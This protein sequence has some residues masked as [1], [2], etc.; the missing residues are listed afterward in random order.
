MLFPSV[1]PAP[2]GQTA[3]DRQEGFRQSLATG[4]RA[5]QGQ[6]MLLHSLS[7]FGEA[8]IRI[9][10][11]TDQ[12]HPMLDEHGQELGIHFTQNPPRLSAPGLIDAALALPE[13]EEEFALPDA[14]GKNE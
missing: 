7:S 8:A 13:F 9:D 4:K 5:R 3:L 6:R 14:S 1:Y 12:E 11:A 2:R 10:P